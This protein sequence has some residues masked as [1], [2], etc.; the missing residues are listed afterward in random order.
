VANG[1]KLI[2]GA[3]VKKVL[4]EGNKAIG[5]EFTKDQKKYKSFCTKGYYFCRWYRHP[6]H[7]SS[8]RH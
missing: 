1:A 2:N 8:K 4:F 7:T 3:K 5:V 6:R